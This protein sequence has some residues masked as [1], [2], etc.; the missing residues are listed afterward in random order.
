MKQLKI[1][2]GPSQFMPRSS[3]LNFAFSLNNKQDNSNNNNNK[4]LVAATISKNCFNNNTTYHIKPIH[5]NNCLIY[6]VQTPKHT[7]IITQVRTK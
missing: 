6:L 1:H 7:M 3:L 2:T 4:D 5:Y